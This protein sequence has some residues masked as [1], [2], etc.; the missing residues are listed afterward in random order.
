MSARIGARGARVSVFA[1]AAALA[2]L[3]VSA[4]AC[5]TGAHPHAQHL[6][7]ERAS[8]NGAR[9]VTPTEA[10]ARRVATNLGFDPHQ[11][12][13]EL[14][15]RYV[16]RLGDERRTE[17]VHRW[18]VRG[19]RD[20][21]TFAEGGH[22]YDVVVDLLTRRATGTIDGRPLEAGDAS[23]MAGELAYARWVNDS[24]WLSVPLELV[25]PLAA[26][27]EGSPASRDFVAPF[28]L[29]LDGAAE[30]ERAHIRFEEVDVLRALRAE[31]F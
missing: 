16:A 10:L 18:D 24:Y 3:T 28:E 31:D 30:N 22:A 21:V 15:F 8:A 13:A 7:P 11:E 26:S 20:H 5:T 1:G 27:P 23:A 9:E 2:F 29:S 12:I 19:S 14:R 4:T 17:A 6:P 25:A